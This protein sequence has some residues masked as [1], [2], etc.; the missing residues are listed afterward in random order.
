MEHDHDRLAAQ[1]E[2]LLADDS[3]SQQPLYQAL[4]QLWRH[5]QDLELRIGRISQISDGFQSII[6]QRELTLT[7]KL[8][9]HERQLHK[10]ARISDRYQHIMSDMNWALQQASSQDELTKLPNRRNMIERLKQQSAHS[11]RHALHASHAGSG[12]FQTDQ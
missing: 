6:K 2:Q 12:F 9:K 8:A 5:Y 4:M 7:Q 3:L 10:I 11:E 1:I